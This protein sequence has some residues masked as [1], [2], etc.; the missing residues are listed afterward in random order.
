MGWMRG[1][2]RTPP[3]FIDHGAGPSFTDVDGN[4][5]LDFNVCDLS[6]TMG[7][8]PPPIVD[9]VS[10]QVGKGAH[11]LLPVA[12]AIDVAEDL[13]RRTGVPF[14][15]FTLSAS[16][17]NTEVIRIARFVTGRQKIIVFSGKYHGHIDETLVDDDHDG[18]APAL[19]GISADAI[20]N[21]VVIPFNSP[22]ALEQA[23]RDEDVAL[24][25]ME[26]ALTNCNVVLPEPGFLDDVRRITRK[27]GSLLCYD[28]AHT[29]QFAYGGLVGDW[30]LE[31]D[32]AVVGKG[33]GSG[34]SFA[35][36]G[37]SAAIAEIVER[38]IDDDV[39][40]PGLA[41]GGT[42]YA[43]AIAV[44]AAKASLTDVLTPDNYARIVTLGQRLADGLDGIFAGKGLPWVA[45]RLG[46]RS[47]YCLAPEL[48]KDFCDAE[49]SLD[50]ELID[51]RRVYMAN[52]GIWDA[53]ASAGPQ[54]SFAHREDHVDRYLEIAG[55]FLDDVLA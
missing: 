49:A 14:W 34:V 24:V 32:F 46:P 3:I 21:T 16:G 39:L 12:D 35:L 7:F 30:A 20:A 4:R 44:A 9:A 10:R 48:P 17:A 41:T 55:E 18:A 22:A 29:F 36:Y 1:L 33:M 26:P 40:A 11:Y 47:G 27:Y 23:L 28:E 52:R 54:V 15:Q 50:Y 31:T 45:F 8:G 19:L 6:M 25:L 42:T 13:A 2:Y 38:H 43:S 51:T 5:Y 37:M 53:V